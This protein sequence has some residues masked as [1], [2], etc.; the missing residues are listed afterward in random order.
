MAEFNANHIQ[1]YRPLLGGIAICNLALG[2]IGTLGFV[3]TTNDAD[4]W[5][6]SCYHV[7]VGRG[8]Q[9]SAGITESIVFPFEQA[10]QPVI[11]EITDATVDA[12]V[13]CA[14]A[15]VVNT[16][17]AGQILGLGKL[18]LPPRQPTVRMRV[19][20]SGAATG[21]TEGRVDRV[22]TDARGLESVVI[23]CPDFPADYELS[24]GGD[25]GALWVDADSL[26]PVALH[27]GGNA[28]GQFASVEARPILQVLRALSPLQF[29]PG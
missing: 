6:V 14:A 27:L 10:P 21:L 9:I 29:V 1:P 11:G 13:D 3:A 7:L 17:A 12:I 26:A 5:I 28:R 23:S 22:T 19:I 2:E 15:R 4:R 18:T 25:S 20:K 8:R 24:K 16:T